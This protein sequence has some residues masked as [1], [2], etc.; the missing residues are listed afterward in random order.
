MRPRGLPVLALCLLAVSVSAAPEDPG[1]LALRRLRS[2][3][4]ASRREMIEALVAN[5]APARNGPTDRIVATLRKLIVKERDPE[6]RGLVARALAGVGGDSERL[7]VV[8]RCVRERDD[9]AFPGYL[10][11]LEGATDETVIQAICRG[12]TSAEIEVRA[13]GVLTLALGRVEG[14]QALRTLFRLAARNHPWAV[15]NGAVI[16]LRHKRHAEVVALLVRR[17]SARDCGIRAM[18]RSALIE[19]TGLDLG[20]DRKR[21]EAWW[22]DVEGEFRFPD[23]SREPLGPGGKAYAPATPLLPRYYGIPIRGRRVV[24]CFDLSASMW[25]PTFDAAAEELVRAV[26]TLPPRYAFSVVFFNQYVWRWREKPSPALPWAKEALFEHLPTLETKSFTNIHDALEKALGLAGRGRFAV[27]PAPGVDDIFLISDGEPNRGR[28]RDTKG[29][30]RSIL[31]LNTPRAARIHCIA[32]GDKPRVL[33]EKV[34]REN[35]GEFVG[36]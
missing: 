26:K 27:S 35:G 36:R 24:F 17:L 12:A 30:A 22:D 32:L 7:L 4:P 28:Y 15:A 2:G 3:D 21:W 19:L 34:A 14:D 9:R 33:L 23:P 31:R 10:A 18:S 6:T 11:A 8:E 20:E 25:G 29:I 1:L 5:P 13:R 16:A